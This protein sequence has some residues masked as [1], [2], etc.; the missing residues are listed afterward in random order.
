M[1]RFIV[2][3]LAICVVTVV[4][5]S[6][7][8][9]GALYL[10]PGDPIDFLLGNRASTPE[11]RAALAELYRLDQ[12]PLER[13]L[14]W[15]S[16]LVHGD[17]GTS[18]QR[19]QPVADLLKAALP[20]TIILVLLTFA[21]VLALGIGLGGLS[22]LRSGW[23]DDGVSVLMTV[24]VA[25][26]AFVA[27]IGLIWVFAVQLGWF[28]VFGQGSGSADR[29]HHL[30]LPAIA[31]AIGWWP[32]VGSVTRSSMR[33]ELAREHVGTAISRGIPRRQVIRRHVWRN[34][35]VPVLTAAGLA[36]AGLVTG[37][38]VVETLFQLNG[39]GGL[40]ITSVT[41]KDF[42]VA[43]AIALI[44]VVVFALTNLLVDIAAALLDP[45]I[46]AGRAAT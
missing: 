27:A 19:G 8:T 32:I 45:R 9:F 13:Y 7:L 11:Q 20:T 43:Q 24:S 35:E 40:L 34:S 29:V 33:E 23:I 12:P 16:G 44:V 37:T 38:A 10:A 5:A 25:T 3:R 18:V 26:P 36:F 28:P 46:R 30:V 31:L 21:M 1:T 22:A 17:L 42:A 4:V 41:Q 14:A 2:Q 6:L 15:V 39:L